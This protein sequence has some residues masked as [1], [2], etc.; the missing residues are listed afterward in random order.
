MATEILMVPIHLD[1][2]Y[3]KKDRSVVETMADFSRL[4]YF[5]GN[6]DI[7]PDV[8]NLS[9]EILSQPFEDRGL[10][11]QAGVHLHWALP[12]ALTR[13]YQP[14]KA[15]GKES[16]KGSGKESERSINFPRVPNRWLVTRTDAGGGHRQWVVESDYL[17]PHGQNGPQS[18]IS[19]PYPSKPHP[20][21][22]RYTGRKLPLAAW[23]NKDAAA[24]YLGKLTAV[25]YGEPTFAAFYPNRLSVFGFRD[26]APPWS[27]QGV[28]YDVIGW[29]SDPQQDCLYSKALQEAFAKE[30]YK[31]L[32]DVY[33]WVVERPADSAF[34]TQTI[35]YAHLKFEPH[36]PVDD[37]PEEKDVAVAVGNTGTEALSAYLAHFCARDPK[38]ANIPKPDLLEDQLEAIHLASQFEGRMLDIGT[39]FREA[40]HNK[41]L[42]P[43][44]T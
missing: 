23:K 8:A 15:S 26:D 38:L 4:P 2:L 18:A 6:R 30:K 3:L 7:N 28:Q 24:Q 37:L 9:E 21:P 25:G 41:E 34:P 29:Y 32:E 44:A 1:A 35:C 14:R 19:Y 10:Q 20:Q 11:L 39:K 27:L 16:E 5:D 33:R 13:G 40:R 12:D 31:A 17:Y 42:T 22:F 43:P 36:H